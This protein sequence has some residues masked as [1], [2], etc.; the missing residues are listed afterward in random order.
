[1]LIR[2]WSSKNSLSLSLLLRGKR[3]HLY[4]MLH[5]QVDLNLNHSYVM[6][7]MMAAKNSKCQEL[8]SSF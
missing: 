6:Q 8:L 2:V 7:R 1:M 3:C 5:I 4:C